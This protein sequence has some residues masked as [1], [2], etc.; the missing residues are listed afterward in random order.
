MLQYVVDASFLY[1]I[2][3]T[4]YPIPSDLASDESKTLAEIQKKSI[5]EGY[6][7]PPI[8]YIL[9]HQVFDVRPRI[10]LCIST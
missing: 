3:K 6:L 10:F 5:S 2:Q 8:L 1:S 4:Q 7:K 9:L